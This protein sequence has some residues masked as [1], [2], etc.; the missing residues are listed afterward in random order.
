[1]SDFYDISQDNKSIKDARLI[2]LEM[3][4][5]IAVVVVIALLFRAFIFQSF[6]I[7]GNSMGATLLPGDRILGNKFIYGP[8]VPF[9]Q[10]RIFTLRLPRQG[11]VVIFKDPLSPRRYSIKRCVAIPGM[12]VEIVNKQAYLN[13]II[14]TFPQTAGKGSHFIIEERFSPRDNM[15]RFRVPEKG[16]H[17][18][19]DSLTL[20]EFDFYASL[21]RQENPKAK[22][23][24][25]ADLLVNGNV[26]NDIRIDDFKTDLRK[27]NGALNFDSMNWIQ[28]RNV[29][30]FLQAKDDTTGFTFI[31][32]LYLNGMRLK[33]YMVK[34]RCFF[35]MGDNW[36]QSL[37]SRFYGFI[38][39]SQIVARGSMIYWSMHD[40]RI[41]WRRLFLFI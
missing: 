22:V 18:R 10:K 11:E 3:I 5:L 8:L 24:V 40:D 14:F 7:P 37:D 21:I 33:D 35:L 41:H 15:P 39:E 17:I 12:E 29:L 6:Y 26:N 2:V 38:S 34:T 23:L 13:G 16:D 19:L 28:L 25:T 9:I 1:M 31:R 36:D 30:N 32:T 20:F 27:K 4:E